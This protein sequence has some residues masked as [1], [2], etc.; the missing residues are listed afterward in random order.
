M[1]HLY[2]W[3]N[4]PKIQIS[5]IEMLYQAD[6]MEVE[7]GDYGASEQQEEKEEYIKEYN[8]N[9]NLRNNYLNSILTTTNSS[10]SG[11]IFTQ[12]HRIQLKDG[13]WRTIKH[14]ITKPKGLSN[15]KDM[16][17]KFHIKTDIDLEVIDHAHSIDE[18]RIELDP[19]P[20]FLAIQAFSSTN[21]T[22]TAVNNTATANSTNNAA[23]ANRMK[24]FF[25]YDE[26]CAADT[27]ITTITTITTITATAAH[28]VQ[29]REILP[30]DQS[31]QQQHQDQQQWQ[32]QQ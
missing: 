18:G 10:G 27:P 8:N 6:E 14:R 11:S 29:N 16:N 23:T 7:E 25:Q 21:N 5:P 1:H 4:Q 3:W 31:E 30:Y 24:K 22:T 13:Q 9:N 12:L 2:I 19:S 17:R 20:R 26:E 28:T 32:Q 15:L